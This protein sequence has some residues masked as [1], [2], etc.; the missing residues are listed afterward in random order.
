M[1]NFIKL[2][3]YVEG[4]QI[5]VNK[6]YIIQIEEIRNNNGTKV[7][8]D[9]GNNILVRIVKESVED[10]MKLINMPYYPFDYDADLKPSV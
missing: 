3:T 2:T 9:G 7:T 10:V 5:W 8:L 6:N 4:T 1:Y